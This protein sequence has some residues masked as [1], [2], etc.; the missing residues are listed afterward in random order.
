MNKTASV[1]ARIR[2]D[3]K[4]QADRVFEKLGLSTTQAIT[5]FYK[6]VELRKGLP[7]DVA[8]PNR[9]TRRTFQATDEGRDI[10]LCNDVKDML[11]KLGL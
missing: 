7:F 4:R 1:R 10:V 9:T 8:I 5:L 2:P 3:L 6:Q 11:R